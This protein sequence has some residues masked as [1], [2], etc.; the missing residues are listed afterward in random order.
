MAEKKETAEQKLLKIIETQ[1]GGAQA[2]AQA[3][4]GASARDAEAAAQ[5][6]SAVKSSG[7]PPISLDAVFAPILALLKGGAAAPSFGIRE[8]NNLLM[9]TVAVLVS[10]F[11]FNIFSGT[12]MLKAKVDFD[13]SGETVKRSESFIP[14]MKAFSVYLANIGERNIFQPYEKKEVAMTVETG[15]EANKIASMAKN[16][17][18]VGV[19]WLDSPDTASAMIEDTQSGNTYF[20]EVGDKVNNVTIKNIY[21]DR[22]ILTY[23]GEDAV[24][25][26]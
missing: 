12:R 7:L 14:Q 1:G 22:V 11:I 25:K 13:V 24:I 21:A 16:L 8:I 20:L 2:A 4:P 3:A 17:K 15:M 5:I 6:A 26:L 10:L 18:L 9:G 19:S 23:D